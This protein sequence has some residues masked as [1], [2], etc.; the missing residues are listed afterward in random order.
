MVDV[1]GP[2]FATRTY[3]EQAEL[4]RHL[5][6][7]AAGTA[8]RDLADV[9]AGFGRMTPVLAEFGRVTAFEREPDLVARAR[10]L[11]PDLAFRQVDDLARLPADS[12]SLDLA[13]TF[14]VL[15]H[16]IDREAE[17]VTAELRRVL[18]PRGYVLLC[19]ETDESHVTGDTARPGGRCTIGRSVE[20]YGRMLAPLELVDT[21]PRRIEPTYPRPHVGTYML[22]RSP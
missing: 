9:G 22:F 14:T 3:L 10:A 19:E 7:A 8:L 5:L 16:V 21:S 4:R 15:Q 17:R 13:M 20:R 1:A 2:A 18:R 6:R 12:R 11:W